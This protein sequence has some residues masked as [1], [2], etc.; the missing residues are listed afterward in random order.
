MIFVPVGTPTT[1]FYGADR[2][3]SNLYGSADRSCGAVRHFG[4][5]RCHPSL[6]ALNAATGKLKWYFQTTHHDNWDYDLEAPP[7]LFNIRR[8][9]KQTPAVAQITK[10]GLLFILDRITGKP[11]YGVEER[12]VALDNPFPGGGD[13]P[14]IHN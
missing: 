6:L 7:L 13:E 12:P 10:Q 9:G 2:K 4:R 1:D 14:Y 11:I 8:N 3:G 5:S